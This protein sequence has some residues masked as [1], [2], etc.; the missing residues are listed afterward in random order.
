MLA[1]SLFNAVGD[2]SFMGGHKIDSDLLKDEI[3][4]EQLTRFFSFFKKK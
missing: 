4:S 3:I 1:I 2:S